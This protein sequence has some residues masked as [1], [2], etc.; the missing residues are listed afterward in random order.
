MNK[1]NIKKPKK[2]DYDITK[3]DHSSVLILIYLTELI[4]A[5]AEKLDIELEEPD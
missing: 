5:I 4:E 3:F 1:P 2:P